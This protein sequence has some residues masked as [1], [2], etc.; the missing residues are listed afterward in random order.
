VS[1]IAAAVLGCACLMLVAIPMSAQLI[2]HGN[3]YVGAAYAKSDIV[4]NR[5]GFKGWDA[6]VEAI[7]FVRMPWLGLA[8]DGSGFYRAGISQYNFLGGPRIGIP[9]GNWRPFVHV[10]GG[11][12][13]LTSDGV[14]YRPSA[15]DFGGGTDYK[16]PFKNFS[17][18]VQADYV[19]SRVLS[20]AQS[21]VRAS[22]GLVWRF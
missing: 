13:R 2:P 19:H 18:R 14:R 10:L 16:L 6:S 3:V 21:E 17:W 9:K 15:I 4:T 22:T 12:Q 5:Y 7:P 8:F 20:A 1:K 11:V